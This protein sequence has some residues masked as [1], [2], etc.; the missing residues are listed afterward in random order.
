MHNLICIHLSQ[1]MTRLLLTKIP[2]FREVIVSSFSCPHCHTTNSTILSGASIQDKGVKW[3]LKV[4]D[5]E[6]HTAYIYVPH[7]YNICAG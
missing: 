7:M 3:T 1:G 6:V 5:C 4:D 2:M